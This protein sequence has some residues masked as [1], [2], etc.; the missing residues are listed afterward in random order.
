MKLGPRMM[1]G[2]ALLSRLGSRIMMSNGGEA[3]SSSSDSGGGGD[4]GSG[5][6]GGDGAGDGVSTLTISKSISTLQRKKS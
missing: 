3:T 4:V 5:G 6:G 1:L 2:E